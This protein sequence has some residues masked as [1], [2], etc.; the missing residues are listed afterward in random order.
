[1]SGCP[2]VAAAAAAAA[3]VMVVVVVVVVGVDANAAMSSSFQPVRP[4]DV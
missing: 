3:V 4:I 1:M 2:I